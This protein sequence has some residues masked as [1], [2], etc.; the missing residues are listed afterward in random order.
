[1]IFCFVCVFSTLYRSCDPYEKCSHKINI[2][3]EANHKKHVCMSVYIYL[4]ELTLLT[5]LRA[6]PTYK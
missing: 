4:F 2:T 3:Q 6:W 5:P 1:M